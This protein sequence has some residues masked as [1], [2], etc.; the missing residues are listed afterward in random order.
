MAVGAG[1][2]QELATWCS[3]KTACWSATSQ[4]LIYL[5]HDTI[6]R[7]SWRVPRDPSIQDDQ[8]EVY[9]VPTPPVRVPFLSLGEGWEPVEEGPNGTFRWMGARATLRIDA[10]A[11]TQAFLTFRAA[12]LGAPRRLHISHGDASVLEAKVGPLQSYRVGPLSLPLGASTLV[13]ASAEGTVSPAEVGAGDDPRQLGFAF[14]D[15]KLGAS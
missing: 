8:L 3:K 11:A 9:A 7:G 2:V 4:T 1:A 15:V 5:R 12:G 14:L 6:S 10:P 13:L